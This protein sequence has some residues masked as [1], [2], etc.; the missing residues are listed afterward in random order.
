MET[1]DLTAESGSVRPRYWGTAG[2]NAEASRG[3]PLFLLYQRHQLPVHEDRSAPSVRSV[4]PHSLSMK[5]AWSR[6]VRRRDEA[7]TSAVKAFHT[8]TS[9]EL[10]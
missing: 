7:W 6:M 2:Q 3:S 9:I 5:P 8:T 1:I 10:Q 4:D